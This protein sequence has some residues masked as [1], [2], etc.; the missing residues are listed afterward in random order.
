MNFF[1]VIAAEHRATNAFTRYLILLSFLRD[2]VRMPVYPNLYSALRRERRGIMLALIAGLAALTLTATGCS[3]GEPDRSASGAGATSVSDEAWVVSLGDSIISGEAGRWAGNQSLSTANVD[4]L[5]AAAYL[6]AGQSESTERCHRSSSAAIHIGTIKSMNFACSG[7]RTST[8]VDK[9]GSFKPGIDFFNEGG[10]QGQ[11]LLLEQFAREHMVK[12]VTLSIGANDF[13]YE[14]IVTQCVT[15]FMKPSAVGAF[16]KN[17][18]TVSSLVSAAAAEKIRVDTEQAILNINTA[19][20]NAGYANSEWTLGI[21]LYPQLIA[22]VTEIRYPES[23]YD[24]QLAGGCGIRD[25]DIT[26]MRD[27]WFSRMNQTFSLAAAAAQA[28]VP[29]LQVVTLDAANAFGQ[30]TLCHIAVNRVQ[31]AGGAQDWRDANAVDLSE[32]VMEINILN[33]ADTFRQESFHPN[34]W[35]QLALRS[36]WRQVWNDGDIRGGTCTPAGPGLNEFG[37]P[38]M[39]LS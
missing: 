22:P 15:D 24:R 34:Y 25:E 26:W 5:G 17:N 23:G 36:C 39:Q 35:G 32:W 1:S 6:D 10:R 29:G 18:S 8:A 20:Q 12:L 37:E 38:N 33:P 21:Q 13:S 3:M 2:T 28:Q 9:N 16:C 7:A 4:A 19:M 27:T 31:A 11:A 30:H 14:A